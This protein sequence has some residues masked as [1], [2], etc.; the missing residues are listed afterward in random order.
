MRSEAL[1]RRIFD[2]GQS[3]R[4]GLC[5]SRVWMIGQPCCAEQPDQPRR[6]RDDRL[7]PRHVVAERVAE[8]ARLDEV[9]LHVDD[10]ERVR[11]GSSG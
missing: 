4:S 11:A 2:G 3:D 6:R 10:D 1:P 7:Q 8:A 5:A 9:A